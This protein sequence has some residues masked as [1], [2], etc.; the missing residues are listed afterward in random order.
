MSEA[1]VN[2]N[3]L[4]PDASEEELAAAADPFAPNNVQILQF[5]MLNRIYDV[6]MADLTAR[7]PEIGKQVV[8][9]HREG[10]L[11]GTPPNMT[12]EFLAANPDL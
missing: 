12:G 10:K 4:G 9:L 6:L 11:L 5:I 8:D 2:V 7:N 3:V 1:S